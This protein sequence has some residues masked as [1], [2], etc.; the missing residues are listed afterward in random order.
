MLLRILVAG[1][2]HERSLLAGNELMAA[3]A[4]IFLDDPPAFLNVAAIIQR[5]VLIICGQRAFLA[6]EQKGGERANLFLGQ[7][8]IRHAQFFGFRFDLAL[9]PDIRLGELMLEKAL[10]VIPGQFGG[11]LGQTRET[12][13]IRD[14]FMAAALGGFREEC[15]V[16]T[17]NRFAAL[18]SQ[19]RTD[20]AFIF[21]AGNFMAAGAAEM[22]DPFLA[23]V[24]QIGIVHERRIGVC[25]QI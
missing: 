21:E 15:E 7:V 16:Q 22:L 17:L 6:A 8:Q 13:W 10:L 5:A 14:G 24:F 25:R 11:A 18:D 20:A 23:C 2:G 12:V 19:F 3:H 1:H 4:V 9:V